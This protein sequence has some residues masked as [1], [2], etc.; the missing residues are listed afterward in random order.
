[1]IMISPKLMKL[2]G[3]LLCSGV[4]RIDSGAVYCPLHAGADLIVI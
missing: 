3:K 1:M 4:N 2:K